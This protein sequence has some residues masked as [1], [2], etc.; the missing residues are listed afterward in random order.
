M[1]C[2]HRPEDMDRWS[3]SPASTALIRYLH[4]IGDALLAQPL[5]TVQV[6][7]EMGALV[8]DSE[9]ALISGLSL[10]LA[11]IKALSEQVPLA[12]MTSRYG[13]KAFKTFHNRLV[14]HAPSFPLLDEDT[15]A[16]LR[17]LLGLSFGNPVRLDYGSGHELFFLIFCQVLD[18]QSMRASGSHG[19][20][21]AF[22]RCMG[23]GVFCGRYLAVVRGLQERYMLEPAGSHGVWGL[24]DFQFLPFIFGS[25][26]M[27]CFDDAA[28]KRPSTRITPQMAV[29]VDIFN[30]PS[31]RQQFVY[32]DCLAHMHALK[33]RVNPTVPFSQHSP[34]LYDIALVPS[35]R[36]IYDGLGRMYLKEVLGKFPIMQHL[37]FHKSLFPF[38]EGE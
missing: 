29:D 9:R 20:S 8:D 21:A 18:Q 15:L 25:A 31:L 38:T 16:F 26:Q 11:E 4:R 1:K 12:P 24:D 10:L 33:T 32:I 34:I 5:T 2:I 13:N 35:W 22:Y 3:S 37:L 23:I 14:D 19:R 17:E 7:Q 28:G 30:Q 36:R 6:E 27:T